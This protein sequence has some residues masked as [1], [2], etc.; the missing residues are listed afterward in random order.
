MPKAKEQHFEIVGNKIRFDAV[1]ITKAESKAVKNLAEKFGYGL[2]PY[3]PAQ[4]EAK[5]EWKEEAVRAWLEENGTKAQKEQFDKLYNQPM[6]DKKT[7][8]TV[9][10]KHDSKDGK[11][12]AGEPRVKGYIATMQWFKKTFPNYPEK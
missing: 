10:Y 3:M 7:G 9:Y 8:E 12:K 6:K 11:H 1:N 5:P 4:K 2:E